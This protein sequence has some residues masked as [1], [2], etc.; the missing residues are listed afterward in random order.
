[1]VRLLGYQGIAVVMQEV[2]KVI[3]SLITGGIYQ[4]TK[5]LMDA[6]PKTCKMPLYDYG[7]P[8]RR[9][10]FTCFCNELIFRYFVFNI[11][12]NLP[13]LYTKISHLCLF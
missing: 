12:I 11:S 13:H 2:L 1:M 6:M 9:T 5:T 3:K 10:S 7:S 8:G 4:F